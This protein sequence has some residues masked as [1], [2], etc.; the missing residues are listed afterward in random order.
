MRRTGPA[1]RA[2][3]QLLCAGTGRREGGARRDDGGGLEVDGHDIAEVALC[4]AQYRLPWLQEINRSPQDWVCVW[5]AEQTFHAACGPAKLT[6]VLTLF[7]T[8]VTTSPL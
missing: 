8:W 4:V 5:I 1:V 7:R 3:Q 6:E 2:T